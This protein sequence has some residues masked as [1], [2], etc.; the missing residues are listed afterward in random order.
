[1][2][3]NDSGFFGSEDFRQQNN[4][5]NRRKSNSKI[6]PRRKV[7]LGR[8]S[9]LEAERWVDIICLS[10]IGIFLIVV[11]CTWQSF[12]YALF[13]HVLFPVIYV[14]SRIVAAVAAIGTGIGL[15]CVRFRRRRYWW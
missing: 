11:A 6:N 1:M 12:S 10:L 7:N 8:L 13:T 14:G 3:F 9:E 15:L 5:N 4:Q 2:P